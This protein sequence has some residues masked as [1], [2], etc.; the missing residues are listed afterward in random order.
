[1]EPVSNFQ[2]HFSQKQDKKLKFYGN[3]DDLNS[4]NNTEEKKIELEELGYLTS[5]YTINLLSLK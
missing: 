4:Q 3:T 1:M 2:W 5:D